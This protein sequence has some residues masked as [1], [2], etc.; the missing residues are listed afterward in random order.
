MVKNKGYTN[1]DFSNAVKSSFSIA[2]ILRKLNLRPTGGNYIVAKNRIKNLGL[3]F[4][5]F[6][7]SR[8]NKGKK[9]NKKSKPLEEILIEDSKYINTNKLKKRLIKEGI[10]EYKCY[11]CGNIEWLGKPIPL[12]LEHKNGDRT[13]NRIDNLTLLCPNCHFLLHSGFKNLKNR[14]K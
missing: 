1:E 5:H 4:S 3:D 2:E 8:H 7:G 9:G 13:D 11:N 12:E 14:F 10:F 6:T